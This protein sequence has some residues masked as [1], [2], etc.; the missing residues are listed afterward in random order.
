MRRSEQLAKTRTAIMKTATKLFLEKGFGE[1]S[2]RDIAKEIGITQPALYHHF[3]DKE[4]LYLEVMTT[5]GSEVRR[6]I[7][8]V[9]RDSDTQGEDQLWELAQTLLKLHPKDIYEQWQSAGDLLTKGSRRKLNVIF[10]MDYIE[11]IADFFKQPEIKLR[12]DILPKEAAELFIASLSPMFKS[13]QKFGGRSI[14][15][16]QRNRLILDIFIHG[17]NQNKQ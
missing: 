1:T 8:K 16:E 10:M 5:H 9:L 6:Q 3:S 15:K 14:T 4:V 7:N 2:T 12:P 11:P 17:I 13:F